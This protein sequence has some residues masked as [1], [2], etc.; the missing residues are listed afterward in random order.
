MNGD[1]N[2]SQTF[3]REYILFKQK[4]FDVLLG[5]KNNALV[6]LFNGISTLIG[7]LIPKPYLQKNRSITI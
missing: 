5:I 3:T 7:Y 2:F 4:F 6:S 1:C